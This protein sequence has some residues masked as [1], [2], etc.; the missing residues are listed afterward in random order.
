MYET[1][2]NLNRRPFGCVPRADQYF[3]AAGIEAARATLT[4]CIE[5]AEG[6]G[7]L[8]G[9]AGTGKTLLCQLLAE[10]FK[11]TFQV[12]LLSSGRMTTRRGLLQAILYELGQPYR[13]MDEGELRLSLA[14][15]LTLGD[16]CP[17]GMVLLVDEAHALPLRLLDEI[18]ALTNLAQAGQPRVRLVVAGSRTL[19][20][21]LASPKLE[22]F[23]QRVVARC[24][25]EALNRAETQDYIHAQIAAAGGKGPQ[26]FPA[27]ACQGVY[28][29]TDGVPRLINQV[30]DHALLLAYAAGQRQLDAARIEEAWADLQQLPTPWNEQAQ[31][32]HNVIEFG[33]L[34]DEPRRSGPGLRPRPAGRRAG[35]SR[36]RPL[37]STSCRKAKTATTRRWATWNRPTGCA[38]SRTCWPTWSRSSARPVRS[39]PRSSWSS[40]RRRIRSKSR[41][42]KRK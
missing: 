37:G 8:V 22:S 10:Q 28:K 15:H 3:P 7:L 26:I 2:F 23:N 31:P 6:A 35:G 40:T 5:R 20:E 19:E 32:S 27:E 41:L 9:P 29:A 13:G 39:G 25:L 30:C 4:R 12:A 38:R 1:C 42:S 36:P 14:E 11:G 21:H 24:Y 33:G 16:K 17:Q 34:D 18:R